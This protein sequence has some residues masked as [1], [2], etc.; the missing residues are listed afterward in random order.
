[1]PVHTVFEEDNLV[2]LVAHDGILSL[3]SRLDGGMYQLSYPEGDGQYLE[4]S[5][6]RFSSPYISLGEP[7]VYDVAHLDGA[8]RV[9]T[10]LV[11]AGGLHDAE[12]WIL[13]A[14]STKTHSLSRLLPRAPGEPPLLVFTPTSP[15]RGSALVNVSTGTRSEIRHGPHEEACAA[16]RDGSVL[17]QTR[18][19]WSLVD[20]AGKRLRGT[21]DVVS[22][23]SDA[24][25][26]RRGSKDGRSFWIV[27]N[28]RQVEILAPDGWYIISCV[29]DE[30]G[31]LASIA[32]RR[33]GHALM[34]VNRDGI[35]CGISPVG[36]TVQ[37]YDLGSGHPPVVRTTS[38][39]EGSLWIIGGARV[40]G[41]APPR[42]DLHA[43]HDTVEGLPGVLISRT[44]G[45]SRRLLVALHG[46]PD[47]YELDDL[48]Y[49][50]A[51]RE[52][53]DAGFDV[54]V[55]NYPGST[56]FGEEFQRSAWVNWQSARQRTSAAARRVWA[57]GGYE[58]LV[59]FG[60][61]FG[62][63]LALQLA[64]DVEASH[65]VAMAPILNLAEHLQRHATQNSAFKAWADS[66][67]GVRWP[68]AHVG[69]SM[70]STCP[71][72]VTLI[73]PEDDEVIAPVMTW[74]VISRSR[75]DGRQWDSVTVPGS[76]YPSTHG[77]AAA[78]WGALQNAICGAAR[79]KRA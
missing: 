17:F 79:C 25:V 31:F 2:P 8:A 66:R 51:Y 16:L 71:V 59:L 60:V 70:V 62:A 21:G 19:G 22:T 49:G 20:H 5:L 78:R 27:N 69:D 38:V 65:V 32:H 58:E 15:G 12:E 46:G 40:H 68:Q 36:G 34:R 23:G 47:S 30:P 26:I 63:W 54:L 9:T 55:L 13:P 44:T 18:S 72:P 64:H 57:D 74:R 61:S 1:M 77:D 73:V 50:G 43:R 10:V 24:F 3:F 33:Q 52:I 42:D 41:V 39:A 48:R 4:L 76:H 37:L 45:L 29:V 11:A 6:E 75:E 14:P 7:Y 56:G 28:G 53:V 67:F 35:P